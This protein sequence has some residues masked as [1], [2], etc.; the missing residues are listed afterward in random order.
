MISKKATPYHRRIGRSEN[1][2]HADIGGLWSPS[3]IGNA[4]RLVRASYSP[5]EAAMPS[6]IVSAPVR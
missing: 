4:R 2:H 1:V 6:G 3:S 5:S